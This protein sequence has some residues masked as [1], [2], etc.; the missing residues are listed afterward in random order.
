M[1][2]SSREGRERPSLGLIQRTALGK[3]LGTD[4]WC[5]CRHGREGGGQKGGVT[6][7]GDDSASSRRV[8]GP[9]PGQ[10]EKG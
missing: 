10:A 8:I 3:S 5:L 1:S 9:V 6:G 4:G 7:C 2:D